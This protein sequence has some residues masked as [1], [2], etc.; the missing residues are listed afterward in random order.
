MEP[1]TTTA[2]IAAITAGIGK[3]GEQVG[4]KVL[5]DAYAGLKGVLQRKFGAD[6][7]VV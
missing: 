7:K 2:I 6:S 5:G 1:I 4:G 3:Y